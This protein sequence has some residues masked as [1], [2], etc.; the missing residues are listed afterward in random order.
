[1]EC[2]KNLYLSDDILNGFQDLKYNLDIINYPDIYNKIYSILPKEE[3]SFIIFDREVLIACE[4][5]CASICHKI[6][7]NFLR[8]AIYEKTLKQSDWIRP[9]RLSKI[10]VEEVYELLVDY[11]KK[12]RIM[13]KERH[14]LLLDIGRNVIDFTHKFEDIFFDTLT[15][16]IK[17]FNSI[18][19]FFEK[20][21]AFSN[22]PQQKKMQLLLQSLSDYED[23]E[24]LGKFYKPTIDY[25]LIRLYLRRGIVTPTNKFARE[26]IFDSEKIRKENTV[27][28]LRKVC[29]KSLNTLSQITLL[30]LKIVN[31]IEWWIGRTICINGNPDCDLDLPTA[32][33]VRE[34]FDKC[35]FYES[36]YARQY[37]EKFLEISEPGYK[38][39]SY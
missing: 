16:K 14:E 23:F 39:I 2:N 13:E 17:N 9:D 24:I 27:A 30:D 28:T 15:G 37:N 18:I 31:R 22:D 1:M 12:D 21:S 8:K 34:K 33:W 20:C 5:I 19:T 10:T 32:Q 4:I 35:P 6:N 36:C 7:W 26:Y 38:G 11:D 25:H 29:A 3:V